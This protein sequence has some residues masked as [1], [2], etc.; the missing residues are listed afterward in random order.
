MSRGLGKV[1]R[2]VLE[3]LQAQRERGGP[4]SISLSMLMRFSYEPHP[5]STVLGISPTV[6]LRS[7]YSALKR[8]AKSLER[9]GYIDRWSGAKSCTIRLKCNPT[10]G[11][12]TEGQ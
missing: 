10:T 6:E 4:A 12:L 2:E 9:K 1:E 5:I 7:Q 8:A 3:Y 11:T